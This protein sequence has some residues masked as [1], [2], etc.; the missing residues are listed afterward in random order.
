MAGKVYLI[1]GANRGA[2]PTRGREA[3]HG[4]HGMDLTRAGIGRGLFD[5]YVRQPNHT[6]VAAVRSPSAAQ[7]LL[8]VPRGQGT[9][10]V[11]VK[12]DAAST[13]DPFDAVQALQGQI[14]HIDVVIS[15]AGIAKLNTIE[16][17]PLD[18]YMEM[19]QVNGIAVLL[20]AQA[21]L[22]LLKKAPQPA[23]F[24]FISAAAGSVT[25]MSK[26]PYPN[27]GYCSSKALAN[28]VTVKLGME[29]D[30]L[31]ALCIHPG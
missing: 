12:L 10:V 21:T 22:P 13:T 8:R 23:R 31:V 5:H 9:T 27:I 2:C 6:I 18:E 29:H 7:G 3:P 28:T 20:L 4:V 1:T 24:V 19:L 17:L 16:A 14:D 26:Y 11:L 30:W 15:A 25:D